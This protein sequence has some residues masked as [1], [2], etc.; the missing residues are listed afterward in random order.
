MN[1]AAERGSGREGLEQ[2]RSSD[3]GK[4]WAKTDLYDSH[5]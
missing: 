4:D 1:R 2:A 5:S 3:L